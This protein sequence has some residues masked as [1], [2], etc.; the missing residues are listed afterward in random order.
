MLNAEERRKYI[1]NRLQNIDYPISASLFAR[2]S[3]VSRQV[4]V[5]DIAILRAS[6]WEIESTNR[7]YIIDT[8]DGL[9]KEVVKV[10]HDV[11]RTR[12]EL[13]IIVDGG[14]KVLDVSIDHK[15]YGRMSASLN[16]SNRREVDEFC[17]EL[18]I[19]EDGSLSSITNNEH[20]HTIVADSKKAIEYVL[21]RLDKEGFLI[22]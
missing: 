2:E 3:K 16:L 1:L 15:I 6:G 9:F 21:D 20:Y 22:R 12:E 14:A 8:D 5:N 10:S 7:G 17:E 11:R 18:E 4:I 13:Y 19:T